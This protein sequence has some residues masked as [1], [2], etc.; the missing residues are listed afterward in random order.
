MLVTAS[1]GT[2]GFQS[3][4]NIKEMVYE[5]RVAYA[6]R[7][8]ML[9]LSLHCCPALVQQ[10]FLLINRTCTGYEHMWANFSSYTFGPKVYWNK[11]PILQEAWRRYPQAE[12][13]WWLDLDI[14]IMTPSLDLESHILPRGGLQRQL[15]LDEFLHVPGGGL[16]KMKTPAH[17]KDED[18]NFIIDSGGW[19]M[20]VGSFLMR[21]SEWS[22]WLLDMWADPLATAK[23]WIFPENDGWTHLWNNH[24]I[25][26]KHTGLVKQRS[27][28]AYSPWNPNGAHYEDG[29]L[30][31]HFAGCGYVPPSS[32]SLVR[33]S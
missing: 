26:R 3:I 5:N 25:V 7:H 10:T 29:D 8:G 28:N 12:W 11:I 16:S 9:P 2:K 33:H 31:V 23:D 17:M 6:H 1:S 20:N 14:I 30:L 27:M 18:V 32:A 19:G 24:E 22:D 13:L 15:V 21:R 4:P